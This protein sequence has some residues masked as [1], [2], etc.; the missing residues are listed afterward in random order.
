MAKLRPLWTPGGS[1]SQRPPGHPVLIGSMPANPVVYFEDFY[2]FD[3][4]T[5]GN[6]SWLVNNVAGTG[7]LT[8]ASGNGSTTGGLA[9]LGT[10]G[11]SGDCSI[12]SSNA[13]AGSG[14]GLGFP[15]QANKGSLAWR[16]GS[17]SASTTARMGAGVVPNSSVAVGTNWLNDPAT[18]LTGLAYAVVVRDTGVT[19]SGGAAG[20]WALYWSDAT[21]T[22]A[23]RLGA[24]AQNVWN[25]LELVSDGTTLTAYWAGAL[26]GTLTLAGALG[27][28]RFDAGAQTLTASSRSIG[29]DFYYQEFGLTTG[30]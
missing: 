22:A 24:Y 30:R 1:R 21:T 29:V 11:T 6:P 28:M 3:F 15:L 4:A 25:T 12:L 19:P 13:R 20:D 8:P 16:I 18:V 7:T 2:N 9:T 27:A 23:I 5:S 10:G 26:A 14:S 17:G